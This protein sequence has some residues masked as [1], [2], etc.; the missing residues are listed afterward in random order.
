VHARDE[1]AQGFHEHFGLRPSPT[2]PLHHFVL[3]KDL[4]GIAGGSHRGTAPA[5]GDGPA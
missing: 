5:A 3:L 2:D 1:R 4:Q